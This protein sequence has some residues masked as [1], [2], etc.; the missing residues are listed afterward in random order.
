MELIKH[1]GP[2]K[3]PEGRIIVNAVTNT[4]DQM[5]VQECET[6]AFRII[7]LNEQVKM[8]FE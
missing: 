6:L 1:R 8:E 3:D 4:I 2:K 5:S 7:K